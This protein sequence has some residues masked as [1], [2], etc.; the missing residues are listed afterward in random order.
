[1]T[2]LIAMLAAALPAAATGPLSLV[3]VQ[4]SVERHYPLL[5]AAQQ[6]AEIARAELLSAEGS[7]DLKLKSEADANQFGFYKNRDV[8]FGVVQPLRTWGAEL[9]GGYQRGRGNFGPWE[10]DRLTLSAGEWGGGVRLPLYRGRE[11]D[12][13]RADVRR[14]KFGLDVADAEIA[15]QRISIHQAAAQAYWN[16]VKAGR[17]GALA[18]ELLELAEERIEQVQE[19]I[20][21]GLA[22][23]IE[24]TENRRALL[25]RRA[26]LV[27]ARRALQAAAIELSLFVRDE[28][29]APVLVSDARLPNFPEPEPGLESNLENDLAAALRRR[30]EVRS[31][32]AKRRQATVEFDLARNQTAPAIDLVATYGRDFGEGSMTKLGN[33]LKVGLDFE[34]PLQRRK[35]KG[36][37]AFQRARITQL[38]EQLRFARD[39]IAADVRDAHSALAAAFETVELARAEYEAARQLATAER[40]RFDLGDSTLFVVNLRELAAF[41]AQAREASA[42]AGYHVALAN[43]RAALG[44]FARP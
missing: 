12:R 21:A 24:M 37:V 29:G 8:G 34:L 2:R 42:L 38:D 11:I 3:E 35:A 41:D 31:L 40:D 23:P 20:D 27:R 18:G 44:A 4:R 5:L 9:L 26:Q 7:F 1:M 32:E 6:E 16:W 25:A 33:E 15:T 22:A 14:A 36:K 13:Q 10:E 19:T 28:A 30:P 17:H 43:Y 39:S